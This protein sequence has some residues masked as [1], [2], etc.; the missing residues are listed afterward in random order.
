MNTPVATSDRKRQIGQA[1]HAMAAGAAIGQPRAEAD[2][3]PGQDN[4]AKACLKFG[5]D[6]GDAEPGRGQRRQGE[7][8]E[9]GPAP[10]PGPPLHGLAENAADAGDAPIDEQQAGGGRPISMPPR[11][12]A[13][14]V[15]RSGTIMVGAAFGFIL[16]FRYGTDPY[17]YAIA[18]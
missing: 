10:Q 9:E 11:V 18:R 14:M 17:I 3:K 7:P 4:P 13:S 8:A 5:N 6:A 12:A 1:A 2:E 15:A 16:H